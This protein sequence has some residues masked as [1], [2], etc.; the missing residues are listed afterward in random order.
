MSEAYRADVLEL[1][2]E[3]IGQM[4]GVRASRAFGHPCFKVD[5]RIFCFVGEDGIALKLTEKRIAQLVEQD[6]VYRVFEPMYGTRWKTWLSIER[7]AAE[8]YLQDIEL[9]EESIGIV[10][11]G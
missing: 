8:D 1:I 3:V 7:P 6:E 2:S 5:G 9:F 10:G 11:G 4:P